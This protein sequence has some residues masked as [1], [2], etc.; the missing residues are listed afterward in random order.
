MH[1]PA[2]GAGA[3]LDLKYLSIAKLL[4]GGRRPVDTCQKRGV[5]MRRVCFVLGIL[6]LWSWPLLVAQAAAAKPD[7]WAGLRFL[8]GTWEAKTIGG[9]AQ[10]QSTGSYSFQFE[11]G[12]H[13]LARH[14]V[15][16]ACK[17]PE[18]FNCEH[19]DLL[20]VFPEG[21]ALRAIYFDNEGHVIHY[22]VSIPRAGALVLL[23]EPERPGPQFRLSY[24]L[25]R[26]VLTGKFQ[27]RMPG[28]A[29]FASYLEWTGGPRTQ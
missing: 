17:G 24:E 21:G 13:V 23:S 18:H 6:S 11:L 10:A 4:R 26:D 29:E 7:P 3:G 27:V 22:V 5:G 19:S 8:I 2:D 14:S 9:G 1:H 16:G 25:S 12:G 15:G 28:Q 20:Y